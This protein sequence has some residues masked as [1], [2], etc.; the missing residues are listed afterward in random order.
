MMH[1]EGS[2]VFPRAKPIRVER[3]LVPVGNVHG[4]EGVEIYA[5]ILRK[6]VVR[7]S[8]YR[9]NPDGI[10]GQPNHARTATAEPGLSVTAP[11]A[12]QALEIIHPVLAND[13][14]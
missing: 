14:D 10:A 1:A 2:R 9:W 12:D 3:L 8:V 6:A 11:L 5:I 4:A 13:L 7:G